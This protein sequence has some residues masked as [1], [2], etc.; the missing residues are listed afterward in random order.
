[1]SVKDEIERIS[2]NITQSFDALAE[3]GVDV[4]EDA[5]SN[6][7]PQL[8][9]EIPEPS[10][11]SS[12]SDWNVEDEESPAY[13]KNR[14][15][16]GFELK[17]N[18]SAGSFYSLA[19]SEVTVTISGAL[20]K[21]NSIGIS[22]GNEITLKGGNFNSGT[23]LSAIY[24]GGTEPLKDYLQNLEVD[25]VSKRFKQ[26][27]V[28]FLNF[29]ELDI[30]S[31]V[32]KQFINASLIINTLDLETNKI[33][34]SSTKQIT[35]TKEHIHELENGSFEIIDTETSIPYIQIIKEDREVSFD[36][37]VFGQKTFTVKP[38]I[39]VRLQ[40][41]EDSNEVNIV[42][43]VGN[44][45][46]LDMSYL[47]LCNINTDENGILTLEDA[48]KIVSQSDWLINDKTSPA[49]I[50]N[51]PIRGIEIEIP[52]DLMMIA[53]YAMGAIQ[54]VAD[55]QVNSLS[56]GVS[57]SQVELNENGEK[58]S[59]LVCISDD[60]INIFKSTVEKVYADDNESREIFLMVADMVNCASDI[61]VD[62]LTPDYLLGS[63]II[64]LKGKLE[65]EEDN[66]ISIS[67]KQE[68]EVTGGL[69]HR[70]D[71]GSFEILNPETSTPILQVLKTK[72]SVEILGKQLEVVKGIYVNVDID[73]ENGTFFTFNSIV[74]V[75]KKLNTAYL[76]MWD[77]SKYDGLMTYK[78][79]VDLFEPLFQKI[80]PVWVEGDFTIED[81]TP[82][83]PYVNQ[84]IEDILTAIDYGTSVKLKLRL[85][86]SNE[87]IVGELV[88][89]YL[90]HNP[91]D[92]EKYS[93]ECW[94]TFA[95]TIAADLTNSGRKTLYHFEVKITSDNTELT[96]YPL[97]T[98]GL[99]L[100]VSDSVPDDTDSNTIT[101]VTDKE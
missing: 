67:E 40:K 45:K 85:S 21:T 34:E 7:L 33:I 86:G 44:I 48:K 32:P 10:G 26:E 84:G 14:P 57:L 80:I 41:S 96:V 16:Y 42:R 94:A 2:G 68:F 98:G 12:Q 97:T 89:Y 51:R 20:D 62:S 23:I 47:P 72:T 36:F 95:T 61:N 38:G 66:P 59:R 87:Y 31:L 101:F 56:P 24:Q 77:E 46:K 13:I 4:P 65:N 19:N 49:Y 53:Y 64:G 29:S 28:E 93:K 11:V 54:L 37:N 1:M 27:M 30:N 39:Y 15:F 75:D 69:I 35:I 6:D 76:P 78:C 8:I 18:I 71:N 50:K 58:L 88:D 60:G 17:P 99:N 92:S 52:Q 81:S 91:D 100:A 74:K 90:L 63:K 73:V 55:E 25:E 79:L 83:I 5:N 43:S 9:R 3:R 70:L 22:Y 82:K